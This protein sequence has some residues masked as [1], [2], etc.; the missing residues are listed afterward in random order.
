[1]AKA[2]HSFRAG[3]T[4]SRGRNRVPTP[5]VDPATAASTPG[6]RRRR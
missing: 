5:G 3:S 6:G 1:M 4:T 2:I